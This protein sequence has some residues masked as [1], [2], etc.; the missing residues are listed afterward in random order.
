MA[1]IGWA[2]AIVAGQRRA[3]VRPHLLHRH[4]VLVMPH[5]DIVAADLPRAGIGITVGRLETFDLRRVVAGEE[6]ALVANVAVVQEAD[7]GGVETAFET[8]QIVVVLK[9]LR[10]AAMR[11]GR[12][13]PFVIGRRRL[14]VLRAHIGPDDAAALDRRIGLDADVALHRARGR[15]ARQI[16][17]F[18]GGVEFPAVINA[19][20]AAFLVA[21]EEQR[22]AAMR[23][24]RIDQADGAV[25]IAKG[26]EVL[27]E[28]PY[29]HRRA[30]TLGDFAR[31][32]GRLPITPQPFARRLPRADMHQPSLIF[33]VHRV[34][35]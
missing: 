16:D 25:R 31:E 17:A 23:A 28:E 29:A 21:A 20:Q 33:R 14:L 7:M 1:V 9:I 18:A 19:A 32:A 10:H 3:H 8:L 24:V 22:R 30:V 34:S 2:V 12:A 15:L 11:L 26:D 27:A 5:P 13:R 35:P 4:D 6:I